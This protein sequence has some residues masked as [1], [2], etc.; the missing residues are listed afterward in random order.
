MM[1]LHTSFGPPARSVWSVFLTHRHM[2]GILHF[3]VT[4]STQGM[5]ACVVVFQSMGTN[6]DKVANVN[7]VVL[8]KLLGTRGTCGD[9]ILSQISPAF[10][11]FLVKVFRVVP[12]LV[13]GGI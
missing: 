7:F 5:I 11:T 2:R 8:S 1:I 10:V 3:A 4:R 9:W 12:S 13:G 6:L